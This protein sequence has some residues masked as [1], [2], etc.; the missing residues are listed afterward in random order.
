MFRS[1]AFRKLDGSMATT[2]EPPDQASGGSGGEPFRLLIV[3]AAAVAGEEVRDAIAERIKGRP[4]EIYIVAPSLTDTA[5]ETQ[6]GAVDDATA[7][8]NRRVEHSIEELGKAGLQATG[9]PGDADLRLA[10]EDGLRLFQADHVLIVAHEDDP[11]P[12]ERPGIVEARHAIEA[13]ITEFFV[14][15]ERDGR[16]IAHVER[17]PA[18]HEEAGPGETEPRSGNLPPFSPK[19]VAG[20]IVAAVGTLVLFILAANCGSEEDVAESF[21]GC[22]IRLLIAIGFFL[23]NIAHIVG[24]TLFQAGA[25]RGFWR[26]VFSRMSLFGTPAAIVVSLLIA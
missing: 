22:E 18:G 7:R 23:L 14:T 13:S 19:D 9:R 10:L 24:L 17:K 26:D 16:Q 2:P 15:G 25:Y 1:S 12:L 3:A 4:A 20:M 8:A 21:G 6:A 5:F 11:A